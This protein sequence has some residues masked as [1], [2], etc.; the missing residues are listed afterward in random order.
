MTESPEYRLSSTEF[1]NLAAS[2]YVRTFWWYVAIV[3]LFGLLAVVF[4]EGPLRTIGGMA[5]LWPLSI[6]ARA[7]LST[8]KA[9]RLF[10][11]G[12]RARVE[13]DGLYIVPSQPGVKG[14]RLRWGWV[15]SV[16]E[17]GEW[18]LIQTRRF[19]FLPVPVETGREI[20]RR[21]VSPD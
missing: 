15:R 13:E 7:V 11:A 14:L 1:V 10:G 9:R 8:A 12:V 4:G 17:R 20:M 16:R 19:G 21:F 6:P 3:P 18:A 2:E 5:V